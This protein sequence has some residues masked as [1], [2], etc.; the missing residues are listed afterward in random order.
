ASA[1]EAKPTAAL[2]SVRAADAATDDSAALCFTSCMFRL[3]VGTRRDREPGG[4]SRGPFCERSVADESGTL[5]AARSHVGTHIR[6]TR[7]AIHHFRGCE[8]QTPPAQSQI[9]AVSEQR[10][11]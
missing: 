6:G 3:R 2:A 9:A 7:A 11:G 10:V 4:R 5:C 1:P 8:R